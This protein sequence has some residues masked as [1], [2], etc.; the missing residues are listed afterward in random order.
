MKSTFLLVAAAAVGAALLLELLN[1]RRRVIV[2][3][4]DHGGWQ[5]VDLVPDGLPHFLQRQGVA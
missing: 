4:V 1:S 2:V 5:P 3:R